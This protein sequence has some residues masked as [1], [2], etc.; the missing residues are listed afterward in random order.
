M[1]VDCNGILGDN[2][3]VVDS[4]HLYDNAL[5]DIW[6]SEVAMIYNLC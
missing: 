5:V 1:I 6:W 4:V 2:A 3:L